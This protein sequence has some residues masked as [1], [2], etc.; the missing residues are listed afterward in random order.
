[1]GKSGAP[2]GSDR[3]W[4]GWTLGR[5][6]ERGGDWLVATGSGEA[7]VAMVGFVCV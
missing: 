7:L 2:D 5:V 6:G 1:M 4:G 3:G